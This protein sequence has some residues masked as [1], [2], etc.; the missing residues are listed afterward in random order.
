MTL[1]GR[2][3]TEEKEPNIHTKYTPYL[4]VVSMHGAGKGY[5]A[6]ATGIGQHHVKTGQGTH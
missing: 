6:S 1:T 5:G 4:Y 2:K 3:K